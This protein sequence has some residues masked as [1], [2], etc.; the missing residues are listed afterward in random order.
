MITF[1]FSFMLFFVLITRSQA[2]PSTQTPK[3]Y[4]KNVISKNLTQRSALSGKTIK[5]TTVIEFPFTSILTNADGTLTGQG[6]A[7]DVLNILAAKHNFSYEVI[8]P[9]YNYF[10]ND[11]V[12]SGT[13]LGLLLNLVRFLG[14]SDV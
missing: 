11:S 5:V 4:I 10:Y 14:K 3:Y 12:L 6:A 1:A 2:L 13:A 8:R 9:T 7:F